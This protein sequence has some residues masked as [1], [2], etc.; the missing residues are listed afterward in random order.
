MTTVT[1]P[2]KYAEA[3]R[4][5]GD[6]QM[7]VDLALQRYTIEQI[8]AKIAALRQR[9]HAYEI[10]YGLDYSTFIRRI[11]HEES[12]VCEIE[13][14]GNPLWERDQADW[15]FCVKGIEDWTHTLQTILL[16]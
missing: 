5:L 8:T 6:V 9:A 11:T 13:A 1:I 12:F 15:E 10:K 4:A 3:L 16:T 14:T 7:A 2:D